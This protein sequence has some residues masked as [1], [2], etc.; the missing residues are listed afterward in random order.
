[1]IHHTAVRS[2]PIIRG[3]AQ[4]CTLSPT[5][6]LIYI[7]DLMCEIEKHSELG[8]KF[9]KNEMFGI[10]FAD[11]FVGIAETGSALQTLID[12]AHNYSKP[13]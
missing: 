3:V 2:F 13:W 10:L 1:M 9:S 6:F 7:N 12:T 11:N 4:C 5:L 8:V